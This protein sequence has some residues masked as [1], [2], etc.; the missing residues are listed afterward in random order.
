M[1]PKLEVRESKLG[2]LGVFAYEEITAGDLLA[3][4]GGQVMKASDEI[5]DFSLQVSEELVIGNPPGGMLRAI[6]STF[7]T[8]LVSRTQGSRDRSCLWR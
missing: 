3:V 5:G 4:F 2:G 7:S 6:R 1:N 8:I